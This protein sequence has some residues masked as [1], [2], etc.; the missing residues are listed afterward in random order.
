[1]TD[2]PAADA[3][4]LAVM[5]GMWGLVTLF[6]AINTKSDVLYR[7]VAFDNHVIHAFVGIS[8]CW[9]LSV[10]VLLPAT[11]AGGSWPE[12]VDMRPLIMGG[13]AVMMSIGLAARHIVGWGDATVWICMSLMQPDYMIVVI[14]AGML[15]G[16]VWS[17]VQNIWLNR[18]RPPGGMSGMMRMVAHPYVEGERFV[19]PFSDTLTGGRRT[20]PS[21]HPGLK[22]G[23]PV[24][25]QQPALL[26]TLI[27]WSGFLL[28]WL[29]PTSFPI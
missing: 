9:F 2:A 3:T 7:R 14:G 5:A 27:A 6:L 13:M 11:T 15:M 23:E 19:A 26:F 12:A 18:G 17:G 22:P 10:Y 24:V 16:G 20:K 21:E 25:I 29:L 28:I 8:A 1:M 4:S